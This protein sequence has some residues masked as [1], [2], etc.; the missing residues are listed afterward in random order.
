MEL[1]SALTLQ[2]L[3]DSEL[4]DKI[5]AAV[6]AINETHTVHGDDSDEQRLLRS[7]EADLARRKVTTATRAAADAAAETPPASPS[8]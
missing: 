3:S 2:S 4:A 7:L 5:T 8:P 6:K 1:P